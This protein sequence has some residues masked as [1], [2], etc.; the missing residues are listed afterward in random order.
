MNKVEKKFNYKLGEL[1]K[2]ATPSLQVHVFQAGK[3]KIDLQYGPFYLYYDLASLTKVLFAGRAIMHLVALKKIKTSTNVQSILPWWPHAQTSIAQLLTHSSGMLWWKAYYEDLLKVNSEV[4]VRFQELA[5]LL[6]KT[7]L[8]KQK[9]CVY[10]DSGFLLLAFILEE[11]FEKP[12]DQIFI[13]QMPD[14]YG[15]TGFHF[16]N[17]LLKRPTQLKNYAPTEKCNWTHQLL[18]GVVHDENARALGGVSTH[19]G[20]FGS[21]DD[22]SRYLLD[23]RRIKTEQKTKIILP[24]NILNRFLK[25]AVP[26]AMGDW[27]MGWMMPTKGVS[28]SGRYFSSTSVGHT[29]FTGTSIWWDLKKDIMVVILSNRVNL[30]R[31]N[32]S[33]AQLRPMLHDF[34]IESLE[35]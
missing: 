6:V 27:S 19:A 8:D 18:Q 31:D 29:G 7:P 15:E 14:W 23:L 21:V 30:G 26:V 10:S 34:I 20:L 17:T 9:K 22:V 3:K 13:E 28:S 5:Q 2:A 35:V 16:R 33:F 12:L 11:L 24:V 1:W 25:R 32:K 4:G